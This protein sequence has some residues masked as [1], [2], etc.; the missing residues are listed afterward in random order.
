MAL[1]SFHSEADAGLPF[2]AE[3]DEAV[4]LHASDALGS[5]GEYYADFAQV[6]DDEVI[7]ALAASS[8]AAE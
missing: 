5:V 1:T 8:R 6:G 7:A 2:V 4:C 3:A